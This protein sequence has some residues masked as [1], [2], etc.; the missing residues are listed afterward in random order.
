MYQRLDGFR[1][2][3][4][5]RTANLKFLFVTAQHPTVKGGFELR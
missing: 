5:E 4:F 3:P 1:K 2:P